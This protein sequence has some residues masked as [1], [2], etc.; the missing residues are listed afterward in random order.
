MLLSLIIKT[1]GPPLMEVILFIV[2]IKILHI[3]IVIV[4][5]T[6]AASVFSRVRENK[7]SYYDKELI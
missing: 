4:N 5:G 2:I 6:L 7:K 1:M 3:I